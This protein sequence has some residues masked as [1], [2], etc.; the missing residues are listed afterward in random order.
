ML[1]LPAFLSLQAQAAPK[2]L[3]AESR[4][5]ID[6]YLREAMRQQH[7]PG[8]SLAI[9]ANGRPIYVSSY[10]VAT[11]EHPVP[12]Q[13]QTV[14][15]IGSIGKQFTAVAVMMLA[16]EHKLQLDDP[17]SKYLPEI[18]AG[19]SEVTLRTVLNHQ[20]GIPQLSTPDR[21]LLDLVHDYTDAELI[22]LAAG[23]ALEF[24]PGTDVSYSDTGYVLLGF[25][26]NRVAGAFYG[27]LLAQRVFT[28]LH[29]NRTRIISDADIIPDRASGYEMNAA[30]ILHNQTH[31]SP[32]LN[33][34][35]DGSLYS[36]VLDLAKWDRALYGDAILPQPQLQRMW[37]VDPHRNGHRPLHHFGYGWENHRLRGQRLIEY[38]GNWQ[39]FQAVMSRYVDKKLTVILL[40]NL[41][42]CRTERLSHAVAGLVDPALAPY[43]DSIPDAEPQRTARFSA[44]LD[45]TSTG[46]PTEFLSARGRETLVPSAINTLRRDLTQWGPVSSLS[47]SEQRG[48]ERVYRLVKRDM[49]EFFTVRYAPDGSID[50]LDLFS[51]Y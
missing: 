12:V 23:Q 7:I 43:P 32:A 37:S 27:D 15:Q 28:P 36:T 30:G 5:A 2:P 46:N 34:T 44:F 41:A 51:E 24:E 13:P 4:E 50:D 18:P 47:V 3:G 31:V 10:G 39:G 45:K 33:R 20:S 17:L 25:V 19:W 40:T 11:L 9:V 22:Q 1:L 26:I 42:L 8:I 35:A 48:D 38:D 21:Q 14:F 49:V 6:R 16:N 29:M